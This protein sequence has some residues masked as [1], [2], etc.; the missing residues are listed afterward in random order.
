MANDKRKTIYYQ[1]ALNDDFAGTNITQKPIDEHY[2]YIRAGIFFRF[3]AFIMTY[4]VAIP[5]LFCLLKFRYRFKVKNRRALRKV[6]GQAF[7]LYGNHT[8]YTDSFI[9]QAGINRHRK[10]VMLANP[11][12]TSLKGLRTIV[13][14]LGAVPLPDSTTNYAASKNFVK[15]LDYHIAKKRCIAIY[16]EAHI[17]PYYTGIRPFLSSSFTYP[18]NYNA[19][20]IAIVTTYRKR[21]K[22]KSPFITVTVSE[23]FYPDQTLD[24]RAAK[25]KLRN[26]IYDFMVKVTSAPDNYAHYTYIEQKD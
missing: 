11:D 19:P 16:P 20:A 24:K 9:P 12:I 18:I 13:E 6:K 5:I 22:N 7:F 26:E 23:P 1:D 10:T 15:A 3:F 4:V 25:E 14:M 17:W 8:H 2:V 21:K